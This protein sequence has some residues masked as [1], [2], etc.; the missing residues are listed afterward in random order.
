[1][2]LAEEEFPGLAARASDHLDTFLVRDRACWLVAEPGGGVVAGRVAASG[3]RIFAERRL[4]SSAGFGESA[5]FVSPLSDG[6]LAVAANGRVTVYDADAR[7]RWTHE[8]EPWPN[9]GV[10][11][12]ACVTDAGGRRLLVTTAGPDTADRPYPGD[13]CVVLELGDGR[14]VTHA[15]LPSA[16]AAYILQQ[17]FTDPAQIFLDALQGD[18]FYALVLTSVDDTLRVEP[19]G[20]DETFAGVSLGGA[21]LKLDVGGEWMSRCAVGQDEILVEAEDVLPEGLRFVG[22]RPGFLD[23]D[24]VVVAVAEEEDSDGNRHLILD[25][26]TL[27]PVTELDYPGVACSDPLALGDG[28]WLTTH[29][30]LVRR[31]R[32]VGEG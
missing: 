3:S 20:E 21:F 30:D 11:G 18:T 1:M 7:V 5:G 19:V 14:I 2:L 25:G 4:L 9:P 10:G 26:R 15:T 29:G 8:F 17:S 24:R 13:R 6:G 27:Q 32:A 16:G 28:T 23:P 12:P 31:W 22:H